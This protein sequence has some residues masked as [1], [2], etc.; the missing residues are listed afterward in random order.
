MELTSED[1]INLFEQ[2]APQLF[3]VLID[4]FGYELNE[5]KTI[6]HT[7]IKWAVHYIY[8]NIEKKLKIIIKQEPCYTDYGFSVLIFDTKTGNYNILYH[9]EHH[10]QDKKFNFLTRASQ[11]LFLSQDTVA[12]INGNKPISR[13]PVNIMP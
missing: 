2:R 10:L 13:N 1:K 12:L 9:I 5:V 4:E 11:K 6:Y 3:R 8:S 7:G